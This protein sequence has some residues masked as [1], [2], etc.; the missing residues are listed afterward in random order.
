MTARVPRPTSGGVLGTLVA[1]WWPY[2]RG[3]AKTRI[4]ERVRAFD[5]ALREKDEF[6]LPSVLERAPE[7]PW[8]DEY[9]DAAV[10]A[11]D[12]ERR[13]QS[14]RARGP[15]AAAAFVLTMTLL[16]VFDVA[17]G[18]G[19]LLKDVPVAGA[20]FEIV[21]VALGLLVAAFQLVLVRVCFLRARHCRMHAMLAVWQGMAGP[22][23][24]EN[25]PMA[26]GSP[27]R[28]ALAPAVPLTRSSWGLK[29]Y[30]IAAVGLHV[31]HRR[32]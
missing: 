13:R 19:D 5:Y 30:G 29:E 31:V 21:W 9:V 14:L 24:I 3:M 11:C 32:A 15:A 17:P 27:T 16:D 25:E 2:L 22:E 23:P 6:L 8:S 26:T 4:S 1:E 28:V 18:M 10:A 20:V 7:V 12:R